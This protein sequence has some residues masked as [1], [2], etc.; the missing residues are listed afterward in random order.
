MTKDKKVKILNN[1]YKRL[2]LIIQ[3]VFITLK[4]SKVVTWSWG[5]VL[6]PLIIHFSLLII[7][8]AALG[9]L[10]VISELLD[11][12]NKNLKEELNKLRKNSE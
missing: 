6:L 12:K 9:V 1:W 7:I 5:R 3:V 11:E 8:L 4:L 2:L 10:Y